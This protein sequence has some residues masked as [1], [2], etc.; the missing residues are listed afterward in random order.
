MKDSIIKYRL[1]IVIT[2]LIITFLSL[3]VFPRL[4]VNANVDDYVPDSVKNKVYLKKLDSIFGGSEMILVMLQNDNVVNYKTLKRL[5][6]IAEDVKLLEGIDR[7]IS[8]FDAQEIAIEDG[9]MVMEPF[10]S[11]L[12]E[13]T[14]ESKVV[15]DNLESNR[16]ASSF[17]SKD[18]SLVSIVLTK[19]TK[20]TDT[21]IDAIKE[22]IKKNHGNEEVLIGGLPFIRYSIAGNIQKDLIVLLPI[23]LLLMI[24]MLFFSFREWRGVFMPFVIVVMSIIL[25]FGVMAAFGWEISLFSILMPIMIIAIANDYGIHLIARYQELSRNS[26][27]L[28]M[29]EICKQIYGDLYKPILITGLTTIGGIL[30][31][32]THTMIPAAQLGVLTAIGIGF[33]LLLSIW[34]LPALLSYFKLKKRANKVKTSKRAPL[35][36]WLNRIGAWVTHYPKRIVMGAILISG[37]GILGVFFLQVDT[38]VESYFSKKSEVGRSTALINSKFGGSQFISVLFSGEVLSPEVL[39]SMEYYE[40]EISKNP[41]VGLVSSPVTL[42]KELSKGFY[43]ADEAGYN[44]IPETADEVYQLMEV[45]AL[46]EN[47]DAISQFLDYDYENARLLISMKEGSNIARKELLKELDVLTKDDPNVQFVAGAG[48]TEIELADIV[49]KGQLKSLVFAMAVIFLLLSLVFRSPKAG[50]LSSLPLSIAIVLLF[51]LMGL[52]GIAIDIATALLSSI[53]IGVGVDYTIHLLWRFKEERRL[54][55][56][57]AEAMKTTIQ[58]SGRGIVINAI[59]VIV[60]FLPLTLSGF[61][62]LKFF[63]ALIVISIATCLVCSLLLVPAIVILFKP[64]FLETSN[65]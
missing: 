40:Q 1:P 49:V 25:A 35:D 37:I 42:I 24:G 58:T 34:F 41:T 13:R 54:G 21:V 51:G 7:S 22:I 11:D 31:L 53:M 55:Q 39:R 44:Q 50:L 29:K 2:A 38:N 9:L 60:G 19:N 18:R 12:S 45:F 64:K 56:S 57:H 16:M 59:S 3:L 17:F 43:T 30:G 26:E 15:M 62:P 48:L 10:L 32:L 27:Q 33:A 46:G 61:T 52:F 14:F 23:A 4:K 63:G 20:T 6:N 28:S 36:I 5:Y 8:P 47:E 65:T